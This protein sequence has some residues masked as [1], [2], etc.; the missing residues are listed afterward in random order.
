MFDVGFWELLLIG[1][2]ALFVIGP[3]RLP[4]FVRVAGLWMGKANAT[5]QGVRRDI[6]AELRA[7]ELKQS[8]ENTIADIPSMED[9][10]AEEAGDEGL[11]EETEDGLKRLDPQADSVEPTKADEKHD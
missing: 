4:S 8:L 10:I 9:I 3:E 2:V 11:W 5:V 6:A 7:D 1:I